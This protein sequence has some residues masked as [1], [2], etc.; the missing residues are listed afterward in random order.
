M[1]REDLISWLRC[2]QNLSDPKVYEFCGIMGC[3][4]MKCSACR[5]E[6]VKEA[7]AF[8]EAFLGKTSEANAR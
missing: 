7:A 5:E 3:H 1:N 8:I 4:G 2:N 6:A